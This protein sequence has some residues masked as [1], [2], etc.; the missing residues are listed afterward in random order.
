M[1][2]ERA[3]EREREKEREGEKKTEREMER[4]RG[5]ERDGERDRQ[6]Q[7]D[8]ET[9]T[10]REREGKTC[11]Q[12]NCDD[13]VGMFTSIPSDWA[14]ACLSPPKQKGCLVLV[15]VCVGVCVSC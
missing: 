10:K 9:D 14:H 13:V 11:C 8:R 6:R 7:R 2:E 12:T 4:G 15:C 1:G 3:R 5:R